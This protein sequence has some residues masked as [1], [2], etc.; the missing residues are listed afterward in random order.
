MKKKRISLVMALVLV[1]TCVI[2]GT[3]AYLTAKTN[4]VTNTFTVGNIDIT[5]AETTTDYKMVP[6]NTIAKDPTVTVNAGSEACWLFVKIEE[7]TNPKLDDYISYS[8]ATGWTKLE[9]GVY[10]REVDANTANAGTSFYV[11]KDNQVTV[12][13]TVTKAMMDALK[14]EG[15]TQP[16]LTFTAYA[17]QK[18]NI[19]TAAAAWA[20][21]SK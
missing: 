9:S 6:G 18:D 14:V 19:A 8:I 20:E 16:T 7:S 1:L 17:V 12:K 3:L 2:G 4:S 13:T 5:L 21:A 10:Y 11:L 15:A